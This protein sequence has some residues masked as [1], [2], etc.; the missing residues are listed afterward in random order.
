MSISFKTDV[1]EREFIEFLESEYVKGTGIPVH[2]FSVINAKMSGYNRSLA[3]TDGDKGVLFM[4]GNGWYVA[5]GSGGN[6][7][8]MVNVLNRC[9]MQ[10]KC[11]EG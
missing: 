11:M 10:L 5:Y 9:G 1:E 8:P 7:F 6:P 2:L 3:I 4:E